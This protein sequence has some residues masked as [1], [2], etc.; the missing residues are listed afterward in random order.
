MSSLTDLISVF[1]IAILMAC[2]GYTVALAEDIIKKLIIIPII[3][4]CFFDGAVIYMYSLFGTTKIQLISGVI[5]G[6]VLKIISFLLYQK[7]LSNN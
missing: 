1:L 5:F 2:T 4:M 3:V 6:I 7:Y